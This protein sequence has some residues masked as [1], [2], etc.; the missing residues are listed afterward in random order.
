MVTNKSI[1]VIEKVKDTVYRGA[2]LLDDEK[3]D[4]FLDHCD[5]SFQYNIRAFSPEINY[6]MTYF[7]GNLSDLKSMTKSL[8]KHNTDHSGL[9]RHVTVYTVDS[10]DGGKIARSVSSFLIYQNM[11]DGI[12][13]H[14]D[15]GEN[16]LFMV[17]R[18]NDKFVINDQ[19]A[20]FV[21]REVRLETRRLDKG[22][23][24]LI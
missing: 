18:Y 6:D 7:S 21:E 23:H 5:S 9:K 15:A 17:G 19:N 3:W 22:S 11:L 10:E 20:M 1:N 13:S 2:I 8:P 4:E 24:Y 14:I 12:N 16:R